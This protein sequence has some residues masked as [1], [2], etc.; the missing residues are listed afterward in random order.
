MLTVT[1][2]PLGVEV[3]RETATRLYILR[4]APNGTST[5]L[6]N[7]RPDVFPTTS[8]A[9]QEVIWF[10]DHYGV[11]L[12]RLAAEPH[13]TPEYERL[14]WFLKEAAEKFHEQ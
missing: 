13:G 4:I 6:V 9:A 1:H 12:H 2:T 14:F 7:L 3:A 8:S 11:E 10:H 5:T